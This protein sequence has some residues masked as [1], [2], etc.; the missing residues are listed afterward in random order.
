MLNGLLQN[1]PEQSRDK[2]EHKRAEACPAEA[3]LDAWADGAEELRQKRASEQNS[4]QQI[5]LQV[6]IGTPDKEDE[7]FLQLRLR[8]DAYD[9]LCDGK[10]MPNRD[11]KLL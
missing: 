4:V 7:E 9:I 8:C 1:K 2:D 3:T 5:I 10:N 11:C 6:K